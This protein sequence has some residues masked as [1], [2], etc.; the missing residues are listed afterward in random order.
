MPPSE[1]V[2][3]I[4]AHLDR[5]RADQ[6]WPI[7]KAGL[8]RAADV[9]ARKRGRQIAEIKWLERIPAPAFRWHVGIDVHLQEA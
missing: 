9:E 8:L 4:R 6:D 1:N 2:I 5:E 7:V 3:N